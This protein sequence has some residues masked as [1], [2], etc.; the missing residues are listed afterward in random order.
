[1]VPLEAAP[2]VGVEVGAEVF[3]VVVVVVVVVGAAVFV[4]AAVVVVVVGATV[5]VV[6]V[7]VV[8]GFLGVLPLVG[9]A[10]VE[11]L[12]VPVMVASMCLDSGLTGKSSLRLHPGTRRQGSGQGRRQPHYPVG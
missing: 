6:V 2:E 4:V 3:V 5:L 9:V 12:A 1:M 10:F 7:V 8:L 11:A